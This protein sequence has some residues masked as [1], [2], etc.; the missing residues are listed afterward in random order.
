[1]KIVIVV[2][3]TMKRKARTREGE[4]PVITGYTF[5][6]WSVDFS[7]VT[8]DITTQAQ[9]S[10]DPNYVIVT[11]TDLSGNVIETQLVTK[12]SDVTAPTVPT[13]PFHVFT[14]WSAPLTNI[15]STQTIRALYEFIFDP[16]DPNIMTV[17]EWA[18]LLQQSDVER[19]K[20][21]EGEEEG[22]RRGEAYAVKGVF[23]ETT[24]L[25]LENDGRYSFILTEDGQDHGDTRLVA[26]H[27][28][29]PNNTPFY[30][31]TQ[32][33]QGD[34]AIV[35]GTF[36]QKG[37]VIPYQGGELYTGLID[38]YV[39]YI[40]KVN[41]DGNAI[42]IDL[43]RA[44]ALY[45]F[46]GN[47]L[48]QAPIVEEK[49][50]Q[51]WIPGDTWYLQYTTNVTLQLTADATGNFQPQELYGKVSYVYKGE[52]PGLGDANVAFVEDINGDGKAD[53]SSFGAG[54]FVKTVDSCERIDGL[55]VPLHTSFLTV[56]SK[57]NECKCSPGMS[58]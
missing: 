9:Y 44:E 5:T 54:T 7:N 48:K 52:E 42:Y 31:T 17:T 12:G 46:S 43:P 16:N 4:A 3:M 57:K 15:Q 18:T 8:D 50:T 24:A 36:G 27:M 28:Y 33:S 49:T 14:G 2:L 38:G 21:E 20:W 45:D 56:R 10:L 35:Y 29:G 23:Y 47:G 19:E 13:M 6:G 30:S 53:L 22:L 1:M 55:A 25:G 26:C 51:E 41:G 37:I 39:P 34:T 32:L 40:G 58:S 11:F